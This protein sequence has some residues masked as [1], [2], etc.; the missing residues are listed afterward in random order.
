[1]FQKNYR[2]EALLIALGL[3]IMGFC[4]KAGIDNFVNK[5]REVTVK[6]LSEREVMADKVTWPILTAE[7]GNNV[8]ELYNSIS[9][10]NATVVRFLKQNGLSDK[11]ITVGSP[12]VND[13]MAQNYVN[14]N[15]TTRYNVTSVITVTSNQVEKVRSIMSRQS[16]LLKEGVAVVRG[17]YENSSAVRYEYTGFKKIKPQM[18]DEAIAGARTTAEQFATKC[19]SR[20]GTLKTASQG[21]FSIEDRDMNTPYIKQLRVVSTVTYSLRD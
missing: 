13:R 7:I 16:E 11:E 5:D 20:L 14:D 15:I 6:G 9:R 12:V 18:M 10:K 19:G 4:L 8:S 3:C 17:D 1:M 21:V 2:I